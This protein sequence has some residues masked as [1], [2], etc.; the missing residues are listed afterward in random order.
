MVY[1]QTRPACSVQVA[2]KF[3]IERGAAEGG[4][5]CLNKIKTIFGQK[6]LILYIENNI[7]WTFQFAPE[8]KNE[9]FF[10]F[11]SEPVHPQILPL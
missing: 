3:K 1:D 5:G 6:S 9:I 7:S 8:T 11:G 4:G 10:H 2:M